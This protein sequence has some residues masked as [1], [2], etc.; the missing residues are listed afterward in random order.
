M[1]ETQP[2]VQAHLNAFFKDAGY[3]VSWARLFILNQPHL[4]TLYGGKNYVVKTFQIFDVKLQKFHFLPVSSVRF[5]FVRIQRVIEYNVY[6]H[7]SGLYSKCIT[8]Y[9]VHPIAYTH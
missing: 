8:S 6:F 4:F 3:W 1:I 5:D 9:S 7:D 2:R